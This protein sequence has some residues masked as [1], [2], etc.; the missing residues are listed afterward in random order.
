M[1]GLP[2]KVAITSAQSLFR[3][4][5]KAI[6]QKEGSIELVG[7]AV[8]GPQALTLVK[9]CKPSVLLMDISIPEMNGPN[10]IAAIR[11]A[12]FETKV[13][14]ISGSM[15]HDMIFKSLKAGAKGCVSKDVSSEHLLKA[16]QA[17]K[18]GELWVQRKMMAMFFDEEVG[19]YATGHDEIET[20]KTD[21]TP[22]EREVLS[23]LAAGGTN[24]EIGDKLFISEKTVKT[25]VNSIFRKLH[26][27]RR[28]QAILY[29]IHQNEK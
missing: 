3:E 13:L 29:A 23:Y 16:I 26:V 28:L 20:H 14:I 1:D 9:T 8:N 11:E 17:V 27:T 4:G 24:K 15:D 7:E 6:L 12:G 18:E 22:R 5:L 2:I 25:H 10:D 21:L 19:S